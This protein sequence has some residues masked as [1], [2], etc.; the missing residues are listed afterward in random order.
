MYLCPTQKARGECSWLAA[1]SVSLED[2]VV[3]IDR[4]ASDVPLRSLSGFFY[5]SEGGICKAD[6]R[7]C[8]GRVYSG[9]VGFMHPSPTGTLYKRA[10]YV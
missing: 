7:R 8:G 2:C 9:E 4:S 5:R 1:E 3:N 10:K 6:A